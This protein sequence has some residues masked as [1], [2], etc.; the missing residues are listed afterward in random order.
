MNGLRLKSGLA[1]LIA[2][3][4]LFTSFDIFAVEKT[5]TE[6]Y[7]AYGNEYNIE[8]PDKIPEQ[9]FKLLNGLQ[10]KARKTPEDYLL[11]GDTFHW[12]GHIAEDADALEK[13][14]GYYAAAKEAYAQTS[15]ARSGR[16]NNLNAKNHADYHLSRTAQMIQQP[17]AVRQMAMLQEAFVINPRYAM[18][19]IRTWSEKTFKEQAANLQATCEQILTKH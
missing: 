5:P 2:A 9:L 13:A 19:I 1:S 11:I 12:L 14:M 8:N 3:I 6:I 18:L 4:T 16:I 10:S 7:L 15:I 17:K